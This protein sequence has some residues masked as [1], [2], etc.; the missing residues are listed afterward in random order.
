MPDSSIA[1]LA[2]AIQS[3][4]GS[5]AAA[6]AFRIRLSGGFT[7]Q[8]DKPAT[9]SGGVSTGRVALSGY[10]P[11]VR[12]RGEPESYLRPT[13]VGALLYAVLGAKAVSGSSDPWTHTFTVANTQPWLTFWRQSGG[14]I[15]ERFVD[16]KV[17]QLRLSSKAGEPVRVAF[18]VLG[19]DSRYR[20]TAETTVSVETGP[21]FLHRHAQGALLVEGA[22]VAEIDD[23][24]VV[25]DS[26][27]TVRD[28]LAA[29]DMKDGPRATITARVA[30]RLVSA[31][32]WNR[33]NYGS[34]SP[35]NDAVATT[36]VLELG[37]S[38]AGLR[39][40]WTLQAAPARS[41]QIDV[42]RVMVADYGGQQPSVR[43]TPM[44]QE[45]AYEALKPAS[46]SALTAILK[47]AR[48]AY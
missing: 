47:N 5:A 33:L 24:D 16:C 20:T 18:T 48:S 17:T 45:I 7:I 38:P 23:L 36:G 19:I 14:V 34:A 28:T 4:K 10:V 12:A 27:T 46:G 32:L 26:G 2:F 43:A 22:A 9:R 13:F 39:F 3:A 44:R 41:L 31:A 11:S 1:E 25:I 6:S 40:T 15:F 29:Y 37:G 8:P 30:Q 35:A 42:P 21:A